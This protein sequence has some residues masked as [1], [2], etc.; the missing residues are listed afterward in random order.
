M[1]SLELELTLRTFNCYLGRGLGRE[2]ICSIWCDEVCDTGACVIRCP[3]CN[4][5][6]KINWAQMTQNVKFRCRVCGKYNWGSCSSD[7]HGIL[8]GEKHSNVE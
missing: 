2:Y 8:I 5:V 6:F 3:H 1:L 4:E 7:I